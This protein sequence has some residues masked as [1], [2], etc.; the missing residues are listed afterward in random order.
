MSLLHDGKLKREN[1]MY[2]IDVL[3]EQDCWPKCKPSRIN[4]DGI[5]YYIIH[6]LTLFYSSYNHYDLY[7]Y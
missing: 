5:L 6:L 7:C 4:D 3:L 1:V 2:F